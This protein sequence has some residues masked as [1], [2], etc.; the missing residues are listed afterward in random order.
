MLFVGVT[1][2]VRATA[3]GLGEE[4]G[5]RGF[6]TPLLVR[7]FGFTGGSIVIGI[8]WTLW[9]VPLIVF[10]NYNNGTPVAFALAC[11]F[12]MVM[13]LSFILTWLRLRSGSVWPCAIL[14]GSHNLFIQ[15]IFTP[16]T[17]PEGSVTAYAID[18]F[19]FMLPAIAFIVALFLWLDR[20]RAMAA[21]NHPAR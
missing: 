12:V 11:F 16:L 19:G 21:A 1:G 4:I 15:Q 13:N 14:H 17:S 3:M 8:I 9:H 18:E 2:I 5:W 7:R 10:A 20:G 6:L